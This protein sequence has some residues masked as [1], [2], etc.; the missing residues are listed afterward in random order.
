LWVRDSSDPCYIVAGSN[1]IEPISSKVE[2]ISPS[3]AGPLPEYEGGGTGI[4][5][6]T[7]QLS[8]IATNTD[9]PEVSDIFQHF[10][11]GSSGGNVQTGDDEG[12]LR[13]PLEVCR[14]DLGKCQ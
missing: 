9:N 7:A 6:S 4:D 12:L 2:E 5:P 13:N 11:E 1:N 10:P 14:T 8:N 3:K